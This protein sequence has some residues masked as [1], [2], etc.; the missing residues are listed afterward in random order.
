MAFYGCSSL[1][2]IVIPNGVTSIEHAAFEKCSGLTS[3]II[4][5]GVTSI[6]SE[7]F[8][9]CKKITSITIPKSLKSIGQMAF[10]D[11]Y[12]LSSVYISDMK[13]WCNISINGQFATPFHEADHLFLNGVEI[14]DLVIPEGVTTISNYS[15][16]HCSFLSSLS[17]PNSV[18]SIGSSAFSE[19]S[20]LTSVT[21]P[22]SVTTIGSF[23]FSG[24]SGLTTLTIP[25]SVTT[26]G[27]SAFSS[28]GLTSLTIPGSVTSIGSGAFSNCKELISVTLPENL[29]ALEGST[30]YGCKKLSSITIPEKVTSI[31]DSDFNGCNGLTSV[32][33]PDNV[34]TIGAEAFENCS[35][36]KSINIPKS[37]TSIGYMAFQNCNSLTSVIISDLK[38]WCGIE[39]KTEYSNPLSIVKKLIINDVEVKDLV[40]PEGVTSLGNY[41]FT[42]CNGL[43]SVTIP[44][45]VTLGEGVFM[46]CSGLTSVSIPDNV[47]FNGAVIFAGCS[48]L[49]AI[50]L[51]SSLINVPPLLLAG[52]SSLESITIPA[53]VVKIW[54]RSFIQC[55]NLK[56]VKSR[57][58]TPPTLEA[59]AFDNY[60]ITLIVPDESKS[61]YQGT[62]P[63]SNFSEIKTT[64]EIKHKLVYQVDGVEYKSY[65]IEEG[66]TIIPE[67]A[68]TKE[69]Y[70]FSGWSDIPETMPAR[71]VVV[72]G[73]F[74]QN[75][76]GK[77]ATPTISY[78]N[79]KLAFSCATD[80]VEFVSEITSDD[81]KK[82]YGN[83]ISLT[84]TYK[85]SVYATKEGYENSDVATKEIKVDDGD[86]NGDNILTITDVMILLDKILK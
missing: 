58:T 51:P 72:T 40:I 70:I 84:K 38:A 4:P 68:P 36:L 43:T 35:S 15:F 30:F 76:L 83:E 47:I 2:S 54:Q 32:T 61:N 69:G 44:D 21:I 80:G 81:I 29:T 86:L 14:K 22:G 73:N 62:S 5:E 46:E 10:V 23:A 18:T 28:S 85:V 41:A 6:G 11:C 59:D 25:R 66:E 37:V 20:G 79:G 49:K 71:D 19:C 74:T 31:G 52:C 27:S 26:I 77:C 53:N 34:T 55:N 13:A 67:P 75:Y 7:A 48:S 1:S 82:H 12:F 16:S 3:I 56:H 78:N 42:G 57:A 50:N 8:R 63:W 24:C 64:S 39:F 33:I 60:N 65:D 9:E 45:G 17:I